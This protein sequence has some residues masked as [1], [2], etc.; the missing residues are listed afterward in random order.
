M[1]LEANEQTTFSR[2]ENVKDEDSLPP[3]LKEAIER[4]GELTKGVIIVDDED[5][6]VQG[7]PTT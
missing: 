6:E 1:R 3:L 7:A 2:I 4:V 5:K